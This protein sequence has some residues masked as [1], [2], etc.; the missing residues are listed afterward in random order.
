[1]HITMPRVDRSEDQR[2]HHPTLPRRHIDQQTHLP[3]I[4][5]NLDAR[6]TVRHPHRRPP[7]RAAH[8]KNLQGVTVQRPFRH[9]DT[10]PG[11]ELPGLHRPQPVID[12]PALQQV[13]VGHAHRPRRTVAVTTM[14][15]HRLDH[16]AQQ[17][18]V[19]LPL[20]ALPDNP[21]SDRR[22]HVATDRLA[23]HPR[24][25]ADHPQTLT[26]H[27]PTEH[28]S[29]LEHPNLPERHRHPPGPKTE[30]AAS[31]TV[32]APTPVDP[33]QVVPS[34]AE[35]WS[36]PTGGT[37]LKVVPSHWRATLLG[38]TASHSCSSRRSDGVAEGSPL[39]S[40]G[41]DRVPELCHRVH[42]H[43]EHPGEGR[44]E[45]ISLAEL[46]PLNDREDDHRREADYRLG[47]G[48]W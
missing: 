43:L 29:H 3:V 31:R 45:V 46:L 1:M 44:R 12:Q 18:V 2:P 37:H 41:S 35:G 8:A 36:H 11:E 42:R 22:L 24:P 20:A 27:P 23:V 30:Q 38:L 19:Q 48:T 15:P 39:A 33:D 25:V 4:D 16:R 6:V 14:R 40:P 13:V 47:E 5:L 34:L 26:P 17:N 21:S 32:P 9:D 10:P 7:S 28:L